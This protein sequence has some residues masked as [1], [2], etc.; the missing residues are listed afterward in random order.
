MVLKAQIIASRNEACLDI[1][2]IK[3]VSATKSY[4]LQQ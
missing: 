3:V 4:A 1:I 2:K